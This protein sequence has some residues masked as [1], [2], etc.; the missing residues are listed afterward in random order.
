MNKN[1]V[2]KNGNTL[3]SQGTFVRTDGTTGNLGDFNLVVDKM[4]SFATEWLDESEDITALPEVLGSGMVHS[5]HQAMVRDESGELKELVEDFISTTGSTAKK[6]ILLQIL[7][8]WTGADKVTVASGGHDNIVGL[9]KVY[10]ISYY[11]NGNNNQR[12]AA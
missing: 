1:T 7:Y 2:D 11:L 3:V 6:E 10:D 5:L 12:V 8:K 4:N 9:N